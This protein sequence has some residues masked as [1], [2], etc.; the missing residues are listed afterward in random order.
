MIYNKLPKWSLWDEFDRLEHEV[1]QLFN[2]YSGLMT[3][4]PDF[5]AINIWTNDEGGVITAELP[6]VEP[7]D[8]EIMASGGTLTISGER[9][10]ETIAKEVR[11]HRH[12]RENGKFVRAIE[13]PFPI[14]ADRV[15]AK[16]EKGLLHI[17]APRM[18]A[19]KPKKISIKTSN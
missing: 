11:I 8:L 4:A 12:E 7:N 3:P 16:I 6:G 5:P 10:V 1:N 19:D 14:Q 18:D 9:K 15:D 13:L 17:Y 2:A